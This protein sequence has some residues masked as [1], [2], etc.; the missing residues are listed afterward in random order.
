MISPPMQVI[1][2]CIT[3]R[4]FDPSCSI[5]GFPWPTISDYVS[6]SAAYDSRERDPAPR[7]LPGTRMAV[8]EKIE[9]W[10]K[11]G[12]K[13]K[14]ILWVHG[15]AGAG[16]S[17]IAQTVAETYAGRNELAASFFFARTVASRN[18]SKHLFPTIAVQIALLA[19]ERRQK[20][21][22]TLKSNPWIAERALGSVDLVASLFQQGSGLAPSSPFLVV[23][24]GLD[25]C[26][27][28]DDQCRILAQIAHMVNIHHLPLRFLIV[29]RPEAYLCEA[30]DEPDL[31][32]IT[33]ILSLHGD[34]KARDDVSIYLQSELARIYD[35]RRHRDIMEFVPRPW[36][37]DD[38]IRRLGD[39]SGGYFIYA[40]TVVGF[41]DEESFSPLD[42][43][44]QVLDGPNSAVPP[45]ESSPFAE[46]DKLYMQI[47]SSYP[48]SALP[49]LKRILG[50]AI[51][52][53]SESLHYN[54]TVG[55]I[56]AL[57]C[58]SRG[59]TKL[60]LRGMRS[61]VSLEQWDNGE[62]IIYLNH[63]SFRG[64]LLD[65]ERSKDYHVDSEEWMYT[66]F[67]DAFAFGCG[68][69]GLSLDAGTEPALQHRKGL[70]FTITS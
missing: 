49:M 66:A 17:A 59:Q 67:C 5:L 24:D 64:F 60:M 29:S 7:C 19:P 40:A 46:L 8:L 70:F 27:G 1:S 3:L 69:L 28:H 36:P 34:L 35:S 6:M 65:T 57:L 32:N 68:L 43:L 21:D 52:P 30:F 54:I 31:A 38:V 53:A 2:D 62:A 50:F 41:V 45:S 55:E 9:T 4:N 11:A 22:G 33:K 10:A 44:D 58:L 48:T 56:D 61:L 51:F 20:L 47:L 18:A 63:A 42:R 23:I 12:S 16:K 14:S 26:Q 13:G 39:K 15:P 37:S 25:E